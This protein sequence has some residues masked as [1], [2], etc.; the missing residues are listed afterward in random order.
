MEQALNNPRLCQSRDGKPRA[1]GAFS[2]LVH[3]RRYLNTLK[4]VL[5]YSNGSSGFW[6]SLTKRMSFEPH[7]VQTPISVAVEGL[8]VDQQPG[9]VPCHTPPV[10]P[11]HTWL[12]ALLPVWP[13]WVFRPRHTLFKLEACAGAG[14]FMA[15]YSCRAE[16]LACSPFHFV[17]PESL[18]FVLCVQKSSQE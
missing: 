11:G 15:G 17:R 10:R 13:Q 12:P 18:H 16:K 14:L 9:L 1:T 3:L 5:G 4:T 7:R 8:G 2:G 6:L